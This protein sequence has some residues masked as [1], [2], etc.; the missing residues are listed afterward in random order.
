MERFTG[1]LCLF[2][3]SSSRVIDE[4][5]N[6]NNINLNLNLN[7]LKCRLECLFNYESTINN[8]SSYEIKFQE[9]YYHHCLQ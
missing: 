3:Y 8:D 9:L 2:F 1:H 7:V 6:K 4:R 5:I